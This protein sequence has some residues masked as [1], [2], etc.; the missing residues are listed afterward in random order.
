MLFLPV[1]VMKSIVLSRRTIIRN[2][3]TGSSEL[4]IFYNPNG[5]QNRLQFEDWGWI[6]FFELRLS[7]SVVRKPNKT[8][9][10]TF[11][12]SAELSKRVGYL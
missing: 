9:I 1:T 8:H 7:N 10:H 5:R 2:V 3:K 6:S 11:N 4:I 12:N